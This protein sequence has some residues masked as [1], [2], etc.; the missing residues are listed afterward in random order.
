MSDDV[1]L[2][3]KA[4]NVPMIEGKMLEESDIGRGVWYVPTH[5]KE[6]DYSQWEEGV[7]SSFRFDSEG[8]PAI[9]I[10]YKSPDG[11]RTEASCLKWRPI[12]ILEKDFNKIVLET[13]K[14]SLAPINLIKEKIAEFRGDRQKIS[15]FFLGRWK[16]NEEIADEN[17]NRN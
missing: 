13:H 8:K 2:S 4:P 10:R 14:W 11:A 15:E 1:Y 3:S 5:A 17:T 6:G 16:T 7:L 9:F 12:L